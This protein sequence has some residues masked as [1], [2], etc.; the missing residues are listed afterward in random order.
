[1]ADAIRPAFDLLPYEADWEAARAWQAA[2]EAIDRFLTWHG[3][4]GREVVAAELDFDVVTEVPG[5]QVRLVGAVDLVD[6]GPD[7]V[8]V[9]DFK[10]GKTVPTRAD[11]ACDLQLGVYQRAIADV[12]QVAGRTVAG[13]RL[14]YLAKGSGKPTCREQA[15]LTPDDS[16]LDEAFADAVHTLRSEELPARPDLTKRCERC[17][18][19]PIC[20]AWGQLEWID[21]PRRPS[22]PAIRRCCRGSSHERR[23][24]PWRRRRRSPACRTPAGSDG[25]TTRGGAQRARGPSRRDRR[26]RLGQ[27]GGDGGAHGRAGGPRYL[28]GR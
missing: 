18:L 23:T 15:G 7:G 6:A 24:R 10:T 14:V 22:R 4:R 8:E 25:G 2:R 3:A 27:N 16:W 5:D 11:A 12:E 21:T 1:M 20:P 19:R 9:V 26:R 13:A 28:C 17:S